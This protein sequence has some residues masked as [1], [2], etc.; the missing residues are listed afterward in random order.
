MSQFKYE[1]L[2]KETAQAL[3]CFIE[4][5][6]RDRLRFGNNQIGEL[7]EDKVKLITTYA[8]F[9]LTNINNQQD[10]NGA[11]YS[12]LKDLK[13]ED[14]GKLYVRY[15]NTWK[16]I[17]E[18]QLKGE[19][20]DRGASNYEVWKSQGFNG[21][22]ADYFNYLKG[23]KGD[24][25][26]QGIQGIQGIQGATGLQGERGERGLTGER[27]LKGDKGE[28]GRDVDPATINRINSEIS[29]KVDKVSGKQLST[30]DFTNDL[31]SK[32]E[33]IDLSLKLD[34]GG[35]TGTAKDLSDKLENILTL[36]NSNNV[37]LDTLQEIVDYITINR[38]KLE[39]L[40]ISN[41][42]GLVQALNN[43]A[44][45]NHNHDDRYLPKT[46]KPT[47]L[48]VQNK[49]DNLANT[50][51]IN[52][53]QRKI[54]DIN[55]VLSQKASTN[56]SHNWNDINNKPTITKTGNKY[57]IDGLGG[58]IDI[59]PGIQLPSWIGQTKPEYNW[60]EISG[61]PELDFLP[62]SGGTINGNITS[63]NFIKKNS[64]NE[65]ALLGG[66]GDIN[67]SE[68]KNENIKIGGRNLI[69]NSKPRIS[70][71]F[72]VYG[73]IKWYDLSQNLEVGA[74]YVL[75]FKNYKT[76]PR[77][78]L[79]NSG[80][81]DTQEIYNGIPFTALIAY[82]KLFVHTKEVPYEC[83]FEMLKFEKG[84]KATDW[85]AAPEDFSIGGR[86]Y[87]PVSHYYKTNM[88]YCGNN[89]TASNY[90]N[91]QAILFT[92]NTP[93]ENWVRLYANPNVNTYNYLANKTL[94]ASFDL[95][96]I[97][98][99]LASPN[100]YGGSFMS[101]KDMKPVSGSIVLN[102][103]VR[104]YTTFIPD[105]NNWSIHLGFAYLKGKYL[106]KN[107]KI[108]VGNTPT[109]W[110][111]SPE[112]IGNPIYY[113]TITNTHTFL[114]KNSSVHIGSGSNI[115]NAPS[116]HYY[117]M[118]G[119]THSDSNWGFIIAK[120]IS[121]D[122]KSLYIKQVIGGTYK[123]WFKI[124]ENDPVGNIIN[125]T[126]QILP[127]EADKVIFITNSVDNC[128]LNVFPDKCSVSFRK[129]FDGGYVNFTCLDRNIIY[130]GDN[131]F[132]GKKGSTAVVSIYENDCY[133]DI[134]NV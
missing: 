76:E 59:P 38:T 72:S 5:Y 18:V 92:V 49:P 133:I 12:Y 114:N 79:W 87:L 60:T 116:L 86:N 67:L 45:L 65:K 35:Y 26:E 56:H 29:G 53:L 66:G 132:N 70:Q 57:T 125:G 51:Q 20:G 84:N 102:K 10:F 1:K 117:E 6:K 9:N 39:Q 93:N 110:T 14:D 120:N 101:Y 7:T 34:K 124:K 41:I 44:D 121:E 30:N 2:I 83:D 123:D 109:D 13:T 127:N 25:G 80:W 54:N 100:F 103:W 46:Y 68:L 74:T 77:F 91:E 128:A 81:G 50:G 4:E 21:T 112:D 104:V 97:E 131:Q 15:N 52:D 19:K 61:K 115:T 23:E 75:T 40:G 3:Q 43:K 63:N 47:W 118:V 78:F 98:G 122:D 85:T 96:V 126:R 95:K 107:F 42:A 105:E 36:L 11:I 31:K 24:R 58:S 108:E 94:T 71:S 62:L 99:T 90:D 106:I 134:R 119:F 89:I 33:G 111:P 129:V 28:P 88:F 55:A 64:S 22:I 69:L 73:G 82:K 27:G 17:T 32:L 113:Q 130:T 16:E 37:N 8:L 48:E